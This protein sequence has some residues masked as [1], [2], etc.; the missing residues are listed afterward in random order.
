MFADPLGLPVGIQLWTVRDPIATDPAGTL[1]KLA[2]IGYREVEAAGYGNYTAKDYR[3]FMDDAGLKC[4]SAH[5]PFAKGIDSSPLFDQAHILG[6][7][8]ATSSKLVPPQAQSGSALGV[9]GFRY[10]A[11]VINDVGARAKSAGLQYAYHN[12]SHEFEVLPD[13]T[14][15]Y[16]FLLKQTNPAL[17][18]FEIDC[19]WMVVAGHSP[20]DY[21]NRYP[22]RF[23]MLHIKDFKPMATPYSAVARGPQPVGSELGNGY[24]QYKEIFA[25]AKSAGIVHIFAEQEPPF[26]GS[27]LNSAKVDYDYLHSFS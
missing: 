8:F 9:E 23:R 26:A 16:D 7:S 25:A 11:D 17:V 19:G 4:P 10:I 15:G 27:Q 24:I 2:K 14:V 1:A 22:G 6:C 12:H 18:K 21:M 13:G 5:L 3:K 20:A